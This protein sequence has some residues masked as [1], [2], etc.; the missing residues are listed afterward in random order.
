MSWKC[1]LLATVDGGF[2]KT[3]VGVTPDLIRRLRQHN[4]EIAGGARAT[5][6]RRW[7]RIGHIDG[8][9]DHRAAL[10]FEWRWKQMSRRLSVRGPLQRR[11]TALQTLLAHD[12]A[13]SAAIPYENWSEPPE[14][15]VETERD[16]PFL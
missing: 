9:P 5:A 16:L 3:Y 12:R 10:Q 8:F 13:T 14:F 11:L 6:G 7:E 2:Q 1:Y 15:H 4:G